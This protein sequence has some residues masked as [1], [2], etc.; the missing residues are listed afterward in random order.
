MT[1]VRPAISPSFHFKIWE[2]ANN[3]LTRLGYYKCTKVIFEITAF[4]TRVDIGDFNFV[5]IILYIATFRSLFYVVAF[6]VS[7]TCRTQN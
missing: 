7:P 4:T 1:H 5:F 3:F 2:T 6:L